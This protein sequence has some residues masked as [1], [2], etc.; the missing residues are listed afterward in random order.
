MVK[1]VVSLKTL[2][3]IIGV[4]ISLLLIGVGVYAYGTGVQMHTS[5]ELTGPCT[6]MLVGSSGGGWSCISSSIPS[7]TGDAQGLT[8]TGSAW[9]CKTI[10]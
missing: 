7:C 2:Y 10:S 8:W 3:A 1:I 5:G 4:F 9:Q 6:G